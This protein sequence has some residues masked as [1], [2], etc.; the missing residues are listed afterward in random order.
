MKCRVCFSGAFLV[1]ENNPTGTQMAEKFNFT[2]E[3]I[4]RADCEKGKA[5]TIYWDADTKGLGLKVTA[6]GNK[7]FIFEGRLDSKL[8]IKIA[9]VEAK[10][11]TIEKARMQAQGYQVQINQGIDPRQ[12][13]KRRIKEQQE[14]REKEATKTATV[15]D[16]W[17]EYIEYQKDKMTRVNLERGKKWGERHLLDHERMTQPGGQPKA[18]GK[19]ETKPG[20]LVPLMSNTLSAI[21]SDLL[22]DWVAK[23]Q[24][25]RANAARQGF[26]AFRAFWRWCATHKDYKAVIDASVVESKEL[27]DNVPSRKTTGQHDDVLE[28]SKLAVWFEAVRGLSNPVL[29]AYLQGLLITG[30]RRE[31][32]AQLKWADIEFQWGAICLHDKVDKTGERMIPLTPYFRSLLESLPRR[33]EWVFSSPSSESGRITEPR[34]SHNRALDAAGL[35]HLTLHGLRRSFLTL[36]EW[37]EMPQGIVSQIAGHKP[38]ATAERHYKRRPLDLLAIWH[39]KL[40]AWFLDRAGVEFNSSSVPRLKAVS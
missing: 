21:D 15:S 35:P 24:K 23:E 38:S 6:N 16:A 25:T 12:D 30:A 40:E 5:Q 39:T 4:K 22:A 8:R 13:K 31:E 26:E 19:G 33:N 7:T 10:G 34:I 1:A 27:R 2:N 11:W 28:A 18:R 3:R 14:E 37:V 17:A 9:D 32:L 36:S 20:V 29:S